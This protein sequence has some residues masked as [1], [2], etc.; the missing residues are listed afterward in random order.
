M[1]LAKIADS[2]GTGNEPCHLSQTYLATS[3]RAGF[4][5][6]K[7][8]FGSDTWFVSHS[9]IINSFRYLMAYF[10][11]SKHRL[12]P[13]DTSFTA[14]NLHR[15][16]SALQKGSSASVFCGI[17]FIMTVFSRVQHRSEIKRGIWLFNS[18]F[19]WTKGAD[20][21]GQCLEADAAQSW[22]VGRGTIQ[23][24]SWQAWLCLGL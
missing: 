13:C 19:V 11:R 8:Y 7:A 20:R 3:V 18:G 22:W 2:L 15:C 16:Y 17:Y 23:V 1:F 10:T 21:H 24:L 5:T 12:H 6:W 14:S 9:N 4:N